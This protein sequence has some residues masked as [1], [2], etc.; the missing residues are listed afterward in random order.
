[1]NV[2][3]IVTVY[4][5]DENLEKVIS[6]LVQAKFKEIIV[7]NIDSDQAHSKYFEHLKKYENCV[8]LYNKPN[9][10]RGRALKIAFRY[11][12]ENKIKA[13]GIVTVNGYNQFDIND[14]V[15]CSKELV[16]QKNNIIFGSRN[17]RKK[18]FPLRARI[19][20]FLM[21]IV[22]RFACGCSLAD[23]LTGLRAIPYK[24]L[25]EFINVKGEMYD[26]DTNLILHTK[27]KGILISEVKVD[28][29]YLEKKIA[30]HYKPILDAIRISSSILKFIFSS[31]VSSGL[32]QIFFAIMIALLHSYE[33]TPA[34][35]IFIATA[36]GRAISS[37]VNF[38]FN[39]RAVF[40]S[41]TPIG[42]T[43]A[44]YY[45]LAI[46]QMTVSYLMVYFIS[47]FLSVMG[48]FTV[49]VKIL[50][51]LCLFMISFQIQRKWVFK[52]L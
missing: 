43:M 11:I 1:M 38:T 52:K 12:L 46:S 35:G 18:E 23:P 32:D 24:Y 13:A 20:N 34:L 6:G 21:S 15:A 17:L 51:D 30:A 37:L 9:K 42:K 40:K 2:I 4:N 25:E 27:E 33:V 10:G 16:K 47:H 44:K 7:V 8:V 49:I 48:A 22:C 36:F 41:D 3:P 19:G 39:K 50:V 14:V 26:Y 45:T 31:I 29:V 28:S 5:P